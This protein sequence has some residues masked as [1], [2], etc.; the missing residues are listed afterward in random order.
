MREFFGED[1]VSPT[2]PAVQKGRHVCTLRGAKFGASLVA[3]PQ[4]WHLRTAER[5]LIAFV[6]AC[7]RDGMRVRMCVRA[8][9]RACT[10]LSLFLCSSVTVCRAHGREDQVLVL[11]NA[12]L[13]WFGASRYSNTHHFYKPFEP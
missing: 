11:V 6:M 2:R 10:P 12:A 4:Q 9:V 5:A 13:A 8:C 3:V 1:G 7:V